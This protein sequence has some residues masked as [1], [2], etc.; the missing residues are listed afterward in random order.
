MQSNYLQ[1]TFLQKD[2]LLIEPKKEHKE[3]IDYIRK[4]IYYDQESKKDLEEYKRL[5]LLYSKDHPVI[6]ACTELSI[7]T[8][9][10]QCNIFDMVNF[11]IEKTL[12][13][14]KKQI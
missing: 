14:F 12:S 9:Q 13:L 10:T 3:F 2:I 8:S 11:Q 7:K 1:S 6:I 4:Q 5:L